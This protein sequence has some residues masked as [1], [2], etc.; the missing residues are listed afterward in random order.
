MARFSQQFLSGFTQPGLMQGALNLGTAIGSIPTQM[1]EK[2]RKRQAAAL[3]KGLFGLEQMAEAEQLDQEMLEEARGSYAA[4]IAK[5]RPEDAKDIRTTLRAVTREVE[6]TEKRKTSAVILS[7]QDELRKIA[8]SNLPADQKAEQAAVVQQKIREASKSLSFAEQQAL[9]ARSEQISRSAAQ[10]QRAITSFENAQAKFDEWAENANLRE[11]EKKVAF[12]RVE[13]Y[14][15]N[16]FIRE[17]EREEARLKAAFPNAKRLII[18][19][20]EDADAL[21]R[22]KSAFLAANPEMETVWEE[23]TQQVV[24]G[25]AVLAQSRD[26]LTSSEFN[27]TDEQLQEMGFTEN[28]ITVIKSQSTNQLKNKA[29]YETAKANLNKSDLPSA[30]LANLFVKASEARAREILVEQGEI[31]SRQ[32]LGE[33]DQ[34]KVDR[35]A[36]QIGL[37][38]AQKAQEEGDLTKGFSEVAGYQSTENEGT[39][40][41]TR[42]VSSLTSTIQ[43]IAEQLNEE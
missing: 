6:D 15:N 5:A 29:V 3:Q 28:Q 43:S 40:T 30:T 38:A 10:E 39:D 37:A 8:A 19:A 12:D 41:S 34:A 35:L 4:L 13:E 42:S 32:D 14:W 31:S 21:S 1:R 36:A 16:G 27:Y 9:G 25:Q 18:V 17:A 24:K 23:A 22:A 2:E 20:G 33:K 26:V 11:A 7:L